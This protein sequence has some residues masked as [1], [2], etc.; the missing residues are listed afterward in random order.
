MDTASFSETLA[1]TNQFTRRFNPKEHNQNCHRRENPKISRW[2][3]LTEMMATACLPHDLSATVAVVTCSNA[4]QT[5]P[6]ARLCKDFEKC[7]DKGAPSAARQRVTCLGTQ[8]D[9]HSSPLGRHVS[10]SC[11]STR[12]VIAFRLSGFSSLRQPPTL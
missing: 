5:S 6:T 1:S 10:V 8:T 4:V 12:A 9:G 7:Y 11:N 2:L 3:L